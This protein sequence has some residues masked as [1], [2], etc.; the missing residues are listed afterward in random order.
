MLQKNGDIKLYIE[1]ATATEV[2]LG[3]GFE[4][5]E[6]SLN[7]V[8]AQTYYLGDEGWGTSDV[9]GGQLTV[10]LSGKRI[11]GDPAQ[12]YIFGA[13][14]VYAFGEARK[15]K[16]RMTDGVNEISGAV[17]L[18]NPM[19][20]GGAVQEGSAC[21]VEMHFNGKPTVA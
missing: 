21:S 7:E 5:I 14:M 16:F 15:T 20:T 11:V 2:Q 17:T 13:D 1:D 8:I 4:S 18:V 10:T 3:K 9:T 19:V 6:Q 12:D